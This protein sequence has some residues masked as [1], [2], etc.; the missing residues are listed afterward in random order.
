MTC[1]VVAELCSALQ[2]YN[3]HIGEDFVA[4]EHGAAI[5]ALLK[6]KLLPTIPLFQQ[7]TCA[8]IFSVHCGD[9][10]NFRTLY[11]VQAENDEWPQLVWHCLRGF[12][13]GVRGHTQF[14]CEHIRDAAKHAHVRLDM[15]L[16]SRAAE[17]ATNARKSVPEWQV[18]CVSCLPIPPSGVPHLLHHICN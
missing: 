15:T 13:C 14:G 12:E 17:V 18:P 5:I 9:A 10:A 7:D 4:C 16:P 6:K 3:P 1:N 8:S 11:S 2:M